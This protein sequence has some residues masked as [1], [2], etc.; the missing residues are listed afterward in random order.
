[1]IEDMVCLKQMNMLHHTYQVYSRAYLFLYVCVCVCVAS[2]QVVGC[3]LE[4]LKFD[5]G[6]V[7]CL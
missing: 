2:R 7:L 4:L 1:M 3:G 5:K 6:E